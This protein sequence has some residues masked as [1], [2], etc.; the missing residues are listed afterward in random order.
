MMLIQR[1]TDMHMIESSL[2]LTLFLCQFLVPVKN[3]DMGAEMMTS[4]KF[5]MEVMLFTKAINMTG[6]G[7]VVREFSLPET[8]F[9]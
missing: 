6:V 9:L 1:T 8:V 5:V 2:S 7:I 4:V 3:L